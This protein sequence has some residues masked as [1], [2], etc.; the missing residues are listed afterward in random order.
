MLIVAGGMMEA[1]NDRD[2]ASTEVVCRRKSA[3][4]MIITMMRMMM[5]HL[6]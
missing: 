6:E 5:P 1:F 2:L 3:I 4:I